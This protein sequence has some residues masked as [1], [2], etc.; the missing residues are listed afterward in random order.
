V[1]GIPVIPDENRT[2]FLVSNMTGPDWLSG[3]SFGAEASVVALSLCSLCTI[4]TAGRGRCA[5]VDRAAVLE[6]A[7]G[8]GD[9][10]SELA[11]CFAIR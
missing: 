3:G 9:R 2:G 6:S 8:A 1:F 5:R 10:N 7:A 4:R 11:R